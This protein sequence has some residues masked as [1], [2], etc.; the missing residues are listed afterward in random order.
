MI[1][2]ARRLR[3]AFCLL[4]FPAIFVAGGLVDA[5]PATARTLQCAPNQQIQVRDIRYTADGGGVIADV[6]NNDVLA[7]IQAGCGFPGG[8]GGGSSAGVSGD[9]QTSDGAGAFVA[10]R[11]ASASRRGLPTV[12]HQSA[13]AVTDETG[14]GAL[15]FGTSPTL[16]TPNVGIPSAV[17]L[18]NAT[19]IPAGQLTGTVSVNRFNNG[20]N[21]DATRFLRG[22]GT[23]AVPAGGGGGSPGGISAGIADH[24]QGRQVWRAHARD[25][26]R[27]LPRD[28]IERQ[29]S[30]RWLTE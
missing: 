14:T 6:P 21:A 5:R 1:L 24:R 4:A 19:N 18:A 23:W 7:M 11:P 16:V 27:D 13:A 8:G 25:R 29:F 10:L 12:E 9:I 22:D 30:G 2:S 26:C 3:A 17:D 28:A 20:T 15:V